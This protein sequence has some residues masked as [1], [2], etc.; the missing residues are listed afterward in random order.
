MR[1]FALLLLVAV[2]ACSARRSEVAT[3][4]AFTG[5]A[6]DASRLPDV[7]DDPW[8]EVRGDG[9]TYCVPSTWNP[10]GARAQRWTSNAVDVAWGDASAFGERRPFV[11]ATR[12]GE[13]GGTFGSRV[14]TESVD[15]ATVRLEIADGAQSSTW[16]AAASWLEPSLRFQAVARSASASQEVLGVIRSV[17]FAR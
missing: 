3:I 5:R 10:I 4:D 16:Q 15:G 7:A 9:F 6:C 2:A 11:V 1:P 13:R 17:R 8:R 14:V 12:G